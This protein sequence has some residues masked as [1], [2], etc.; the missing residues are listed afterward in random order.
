M[1]VL[2]FKHNDEIHFDEKRRPVFHG[3]FS[4]MLSFD[5]LSL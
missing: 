2:T 1:T 5:L 3:K 4:Y